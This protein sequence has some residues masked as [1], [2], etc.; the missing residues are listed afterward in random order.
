MDKMEVIRDSSSTIWVPDWEFR[1]SSI[2]GG[3]AK[4]SFII[5]P[6][7][8]KVGMIEKASSYMLKCHIGYHLSLAR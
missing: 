3:I 6:L 2:M 7:Y 4:M 5:D 8:G 1:H